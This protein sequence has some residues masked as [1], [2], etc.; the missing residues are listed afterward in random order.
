MSMKAP[1]I[2]IQ[3]VPQEDQRYNTVGDWL[4]VPGDTCEIRISRDVH[5][6]EGFLIALHEMVEWYLC[7]KRGIAQEVVD[8]FDMAYTGDDEPGDELAA[9][10]TREHR[11][12]MLI[13]HLMAHELGIVGYGSVT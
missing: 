8:A 2:I 9:P 3:T 1:R 13:E 12:A 10:Y 7:R 5:E 11:F 6:D 4:M